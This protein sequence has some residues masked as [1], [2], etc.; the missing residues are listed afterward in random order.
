[1]DDLTIHHSH[2]E[3]KLLVH[4]DLIHVLAGFQAA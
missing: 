4:Q 3:C 2:S 1:M